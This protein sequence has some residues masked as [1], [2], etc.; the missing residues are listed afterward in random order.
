MRKP[1]I[2]PVALRE[3]RQ[4][5]RSRVV[6]WGLATFPMILFVF[7]ALTVA[8]A[9][10]GYSPTELAFG[11]GMGKSPFVAVSV[12]T[13]IVASAGIPFYS[14]LKAAFETNSANPGLE[15]TT[16]LT[17]AQIVGGRLAST[18]ILVAATVATATPFFAFAYLLRGIPLEWVFA[19]P[20]FLFCGGLFAFSAALCVAVRPGHVALR[21]AMMI[22]LFCSVLPGALS[23]LAIFDSSYASSMKVPLSSVAMVAAAGLAAFVVLVRAQCAATLSPPH[24][25]GERTYRRTVFALFALS[26]PLAFWPKTGDAWAFVVL[27]I[28]S[29]L[30]VQSALSPRGVPRAARAAAPKGLFRRILSFPFA[31]GATPG[32]VFFGALAFVAAAALSLS[33]SGNPKLVCVLWACLAETLSVPVIVGAV[34]RR[35]GAAPARF[36]AAGWLMLAYLVAAFVISVMAKA[37]AFDEDFVSL[38]P[39]N[40][41]AIQDAPESH[42]AIYGV[43]LLFAVVLAVASY[44][45]EFSKYRRAK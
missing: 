3:L 42:L 26:S 8:T 29:L 24:A 10:S 9:M 20:F 34:L 32:V 4:L 41:F 6:T 18:A 22:L 31:T 16:A 5:V 38:L 1:S 19:V 15:F 36:R 2:N 27:L 28:A 13:G 45:S 40:F 12:I 11:K 21:I 14:A 33:L 35:T 30:T 37:D 17:P 44:V 43:L 23:L 25:D 39:C 7:T